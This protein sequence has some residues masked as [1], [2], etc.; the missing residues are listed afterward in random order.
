[1]KSNEKKERRQLK[2]IIK[3]KEKESNCHQIG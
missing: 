3:A 2:L 1:M